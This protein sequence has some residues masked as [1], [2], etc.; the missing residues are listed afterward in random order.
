MTYIV[1]ECHN[2]N[3]NRQKDQSGGS[4]VRDTE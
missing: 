1:Y 3:T 2:E 4:I